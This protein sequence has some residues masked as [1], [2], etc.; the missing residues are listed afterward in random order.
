MLDPSTGRV[1]SLDD[2]VMSKV[3]G[4]NVTTM[5]PPRL[6]FASPT[7]PFRIGEMCLEDVGLARLSFARVKTGAGRRELLS[8]AHAGLVC[9]DGRL[10]GVRSWSESPVAARLAT[11]ACTA[12]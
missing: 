1:V 7:G 11:G 5:H 9:G 10:P 8:G 12:C 3:F 6:R 4:C 2:G